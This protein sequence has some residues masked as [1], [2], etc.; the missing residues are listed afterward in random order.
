[1]KQKTDLRVQKTVK[2][3]RQAFQEMVCTMKPGEITVK[4][5]TERAQINRKT[6]YLHYNCIEDVYEEVIREIAAGYVK[7]ISQTDLGH[8]KAFNAENL[9]RVYFEYYSS[10][11]AFAERLITNPDYREYCNKLFAITL[12]HNCTQFNPYK[13]LPEEEQN[14]ILTYLCT[15]TYEMFCQWVQSGKKIPLVK[16]V[17]IASLLLANGLYGYSEQITNGN[18]VYGN[19]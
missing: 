14:M 17:K 15:A 10:Q 1:M 8:G 16:V 13:H 2:A 4:E 6:F 7:A 3:I 11:G 12:R 9:T 19:A 18:E 5:L